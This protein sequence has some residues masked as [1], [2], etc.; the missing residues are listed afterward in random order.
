MVGQ[1]MKNVSNW[2]HFF[3]AVI[4]SEI[5]YPA[6]KKQCQ[7]EVENV[8]IDFLLRK[9]SPGTSNTEVASQSG[10]GW[11]RD[12]VY[13][14]PQIGC[15][16]LVVLSLMSPI[17]MAI[18]G[19]TCGVNRSFSDLN[20]SAFETSGAKE[21][22]GHELTGLGNIAGSP[23]SCKYGST[24][25][26]PESPQNCVYG[27]MILQISFSSVKVCRRFFASLF[28]HVLSMDSPTFW[29]KLQRRLPGLSSTRLFC[30]LTETQYQ[31]IDRLFQTRRVQAGMKRTQTGLGFAVQEAMDGG[32]GWHGRY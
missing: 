5:R 29:S 13:R 2:L 31:S 4:V 10:F 8:Q 24:Q 12:R 1:S 28:C 32:H 9:A 25:Y 27:M 21:H 17:N 16:D 19:G 6:K 22:F 20:P 7:R 23:K 30:L 14:I 26:P 3:F 18:N 15:P 11:Y